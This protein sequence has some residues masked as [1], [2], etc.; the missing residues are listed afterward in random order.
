MRVDGQARWDDMQEAHADPAVGQVAQALA[1][2]DALERMLLYAMTAARLQPAPDR[3]LSAKKGRMSEA[4]VR[5]ASVIDQAAAEWRRS[6]D[7]EQFKFRRAAVIERLTVLLV[8]S[9]VAAT[10]VHEETRVVLSDDS[11]T[12]PF[13]VLAA[14][15]GTT[16]EGIECKAAADLSDTQGAE[17]S[18]AAETADRLGDQ[19]NVVIASAADRATLVPVIRTRVKRSDLVYFV[20]ADTFASLARPAPR[21]RI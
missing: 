15:L 9:H 12:T 2:A 17:L 8:K 19:L 3:V 10:D 6:L 11:V 18:W 5:R 20:A 4:D 13:D 1:G 21:Y 16:W 14:P 7:A